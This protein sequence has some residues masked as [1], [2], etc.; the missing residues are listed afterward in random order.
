MAIPTD[1]TLWQQAK[2]RRRAE[3]APEAP[4]GEWSSLKAA[5]AV[6]DYEAAGGLWIEQDPA[7]IPTLAEFVGEATG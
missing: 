7:D 6:L 3:D 4:A 1:E 2:D 5:R